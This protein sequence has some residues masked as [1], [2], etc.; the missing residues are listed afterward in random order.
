[1]I[2]AL[3]KMTTR[4]RE[5]KPVSKR[6]AI[7]LWRLATGIDYRTIGQRFGVGRSTCCKITH[8][9][10][11]SIVKVLLKRFIRIVGTNEQIQETKRGFA[12][13]GGLPQCVGAIDGCHI[14]RL[15]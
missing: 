2:G 13:M 4:F 12:I 9:V 7:A 8:Q 6:I 11:D 15:F 3:E 14:P 10:C 1:M 5:A